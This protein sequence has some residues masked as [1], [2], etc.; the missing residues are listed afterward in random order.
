MLSDMDFEEHL[1]DMSDSQKIDFTAHQMWKVSKQFAT[2][3][4]QKDGAC[5]PLQ[6][7]S[8][9]RFFGQVLGYGGLGGAIAFAI[10]WGIGKLEG[11]W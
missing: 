10:I 3:L 2:L 8:T 9:A 1:A 4:C 6:Q 5:P 7:N 11:W